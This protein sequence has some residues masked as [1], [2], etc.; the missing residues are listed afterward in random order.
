MYV[1]T[2]GCALCI[3]ICVCVHV[4]VSMCVC[5]HDCIDVKDGSR[6]EAKS[7]RP[8]NVGEGESWLCTP[9]SVLYITGP[10][11]SAAA[12]SQCRLDHAPGRKRR[13]TSAGLLPVFFFFFFFFFFGFL[14]VPDSMS[15]IARGK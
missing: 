8:P 3:Y 14:P 9:P 13:S 5:M 11:V 10:V 1:Q 12:I 6:Q 4:C 15:R 7:D 2:Y